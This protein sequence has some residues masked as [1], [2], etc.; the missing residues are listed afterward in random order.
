MHG[1]APAGHDD[2]PTSEVIESFASSIAS[3]AAVD[4]NLAVPPA[5]L[6]SLLTAQF[7]RLVAAL[8]EPGDDKPAD[9]ELGYRM[10]AEVLTVNLNGPTALPTV[11]AALQADVLSLAGVPDGED[12]QSRLRTI[13]GGF[14]AGYVHAVR[15]RLLDEQESIKR[16]ALLANEAAERSRRRSEARFRAV[17]TRTGIG[18]ALGDV[19]G[20][21]VEVNPT[22]CQIFGRSAEELVGHAVLEFTHPTDKKRLTDFYQELVTGK[23]ESFAD[24]FQV[25]NGQGEPVW[26][27]VTMTMMP[28]S[29]SGERYAIGT[30]ENVTDLQLLRAEHNRTV[31]HDRLTGLPNNDR[32]RTRMNDLLED[33]EQGE[34][35]ALCFFDIDGFKVIN[36]GLGGEVGDKMLLSLATALRSKFGGTRNTVARV[37]GDGFA[38][39]VRNPY[40]SKWL[41]DQV[42][43]LQ[44][45]V[46]EPYFVDK[47]QDGVA[48]SLS[49]GIVIHEATTIGPDELIRAAEITLHRAKAKGKA[50]WMFY[51]A[52][53]DAI[54]RRRYHLGAILPGALESGEFSLLFEPAKRLASNEV[55]AYIASLRWWRRDTG[56][57]RGEDFMPLAEETGMVVELD[58][59][60]INEVCGNI[61]RWQNE[62][63]TPVPLISIPI[64]SRT[65]R[66]QDLVGIVREALRANKL[67][68]E[69]LGMLVPMHELIDPESDAVESVEV[70]TDLG[71]RVNADGCGGGPSLF[72]LENVPVRTLRLIPEVAARV[73]TPSVRAGVEAFVT[74]AHGVGRTVAASGVDT[75]EQLEAMREI[76]V[77]VACGTAIGQALSAPQLAAGLG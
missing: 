20:R 12:N 44:S 50:Q 53:Q 72:D 47:K 24:E 71:V 55:Q 26:T 65:A 22:I 23:R 40:S 10:G 64:A 77:N 11:L 3:L 51:D 56:Y 41:I 27:H 38:A 73:T 70:L 62:F 45:L 59:W 33:A 46:G 39:L 31:E 21:F 67:S 58:R 76:G 13:T 19:E 5:T 29:E 2:G 15:E 7:T 74:M 69:A 30:V 60:V 66:D 17:F 68:G 63:E 54:D 35:V 1:E 16:S 75:T 61:A 4:S 6:R 57:L 32:L 37:A 34:Q 14:A 36:D 25:M 52:E 42:Q 9:H 49:T 28:E 8:R 43:D 48:L 18:M